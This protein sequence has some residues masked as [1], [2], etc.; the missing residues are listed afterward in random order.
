VVALVLLLIGAALASGLM[1]N[2]P[3]VMNVVV[4]IASCLAIWAFTGI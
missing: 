2:T 3:L 1:N 4:G